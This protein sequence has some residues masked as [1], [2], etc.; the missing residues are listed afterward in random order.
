MNYSVLEENKT[1]TYFLVNDRISK[2]EVVDIANKFISKKENKENVSICFFLTKKKHETPFAIVYFSNSKIH[3]VKYPFNQKKFNAFFNL[4]FNEKILNHWELKHS[5]TPRQ[6][7]I[8]EKDKQLFYKSLQVDFYSDKLYN[9]YSE[10]IVNIDTLEN[11]EVKFQLKN[12]DTLRY[13][14]IDK[15]K[16]LKTFYK[17]SFTDI[18]HHKMK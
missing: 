2:E 3:E 13:Y 10:L 7:F 4:K 14:I 5:S 16:N 12:N 9:V 15:N 17:N 11:N 18:I 6:V 8:F 1:T